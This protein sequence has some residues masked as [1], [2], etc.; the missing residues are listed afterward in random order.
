[1]KFIDVFICFTH[2]IH[3]KHF[4]NSFQVNNKLINRNITGVPTDQHTKIADNQ[5]NFFRCF[6]PNVY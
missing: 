4:R 3:T 5:N 6:Q 1:M 2:L